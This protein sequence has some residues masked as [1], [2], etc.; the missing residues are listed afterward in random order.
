MKNVR[1]Y[2]I[3]LDKHPEAPAFLPFNEKR[4]PD[5]VNYHK[6][7]DSELEFNNIED[8]YRQ[9][10][11]EKHP[12]YNGWSMSM[13]DIV[14]FDNKAFY[15]DQIGFKQVDFDENKVDN[16]NQIRILFVEPRKEPYE[17]WIPNTLKAKQIA[18]DGYIEFVYNSDETALVG[19]EEAKI[20]GKEGN[21]YLNGG[22]VMAGNFFVIGL[23]EEDCRSLTDAE[24]EKY[25][26][27]YSDPP[28]ITKEEVENDTKFGFIGF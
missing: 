2:Q 26:K 25:K 14:V 18:V 28:T 27:I 24:I 17:A 23:S 22:G 16:S 13:S 15:C 19:D 10:N 12:L 8:L 20:K 5:P 3:D 4:L 11:F 21:R 6:V 9:F 1:I 7:F